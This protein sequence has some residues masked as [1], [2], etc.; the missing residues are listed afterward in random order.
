MAVATTEQVTLTLLQCAREEKF[1]RH[2]LVEES[3]RR[4]DFKHQHK[5]ITMVAALLAAGTIVE[6]DGL[7]KIG[8]ASTRSDKSTDGKYTEEYVAELQ[9]RIKMG[10][11]SLK[12]SGILRD[13]LNK[14]LKDAVSAAEAGIRAA[15]EKAKQATGR[16]L[17]VQVKNGP[18]V[19]KKVTGVFHSQFEN[20]LQ[21]AQQ[22]KNIFIFGP[23]GCGKTYICEQLA[24]ALSLPFSFVSCST[25]M[26]EGQLT[27]RLL[28]VGKQGTFEFVEAEYAMRYEN[29]G[30]FLFD[31]FAAIDGNTMLSISASLAGKVLA[32]LNRRIN[33]YAKRHPDFICIAA[34]NTIGTGSDRLYSS[35]NKQ[36]HAILDRFQIGKVFMDYDAAL[37]AVVCPDDALREHLLKYRKAIRTHRM[38]RSMSTRFMIDAYDMKVGCEWTHDDID[39]AFFQGWRIDEVNKVKSQYGVK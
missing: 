31:E 13:S 4:V 16:I 23:T 29:G 39:N 26:S 12:E 38:E 36:D 28:P 18:K 11:E 2:D 1:D 10:E 32:L 5:V 35:R 19:T 20:L 34:D 8:N 9:K 25:G 6:S 17:E 3:C 14:K 33:P 27:G 30:V 21:L 24:E 15:N 7:V 37:E 22:R